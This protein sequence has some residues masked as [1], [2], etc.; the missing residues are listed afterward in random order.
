M[1]CGPGTKEDPM[2]AE[3]KAETERLQQALLETSI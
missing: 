1:E 2:I 3:M